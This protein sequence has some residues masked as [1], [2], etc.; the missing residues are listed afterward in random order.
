MHLVRQTYV[1]QRDAVDKS[2][3]LSHQKESQGSSQKPSNKQHLH[4]D[5]T[6]LDCKG[7]RQLDKSR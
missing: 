1:F 7:S 6:N 2:Y 3:I 4:L 5:D